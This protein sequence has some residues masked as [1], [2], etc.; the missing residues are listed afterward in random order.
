MF[1]FVVKSMYTCPS[2]FKEKFK[3]VHCTICDGYHYRT[4]RSFESNLKI[5][6]SVNKAVT[7]LMTDMRKGMG[8]IGK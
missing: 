5:I 3:A 4:R 1:F 8:K 2:L 6:V 7:E